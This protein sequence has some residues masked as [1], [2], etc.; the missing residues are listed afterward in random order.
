MTAIVIW[1]IGLLF[2]WGTL[3]CY[4]E[5]AVGERIGAAILAIA[6]WP[7]FLGLEW[8]DYKENIFKKREGD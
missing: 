5:E 3:L 1:G 8:A 6:F 2:I 4:E 7:I